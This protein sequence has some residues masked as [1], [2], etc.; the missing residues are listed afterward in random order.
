MIKNWLTYKWDILK[1]KQC[2]LY[3]PKPSNYK[4]WQYITTR[5]QQ[6]NTILTKSNSTT[7]HYVLHDAIN[8]N[9]LEKRWQN[10]RIRSLK[11]SYINIQMLKPNKMDAKS[12]YI[13]WDHH[14]L[15]FLITALPDK[16]FI[17][18]ATKWTV[19]TYCKSNQSG[20]DSS[21]RNLSY[22]IRLWDVFILTS[23]RNLRE[24]DETSGG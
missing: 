24:W 15:H 12:R 7:I 21:R 5:N 9:S 3:R 22:I 16:D 14:T 13:L 23:R 20:V 6:F 11:D 10:T 4:K 17:V 2:T 8:L 18:E 1:W 19:T